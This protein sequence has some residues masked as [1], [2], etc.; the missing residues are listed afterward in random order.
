MW[1]VPS[2]TAREMTELSHTAAVISKAELAPYEARTA[3]MVL[4]MN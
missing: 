4:G 2:P 1:A 3:A